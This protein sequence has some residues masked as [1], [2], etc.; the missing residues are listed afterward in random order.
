MT[1]QK[2]DQRDRWLQ[3]MQQYY[4]DTY[5]APMYRDVRAMLPASTERL[6]TLSQIV[7]RNV[8]AQFKCVPDVAA[9]DKALTEMYETH[10]EYT[11]L[12]TDRLQIEEDAGLE[13]YTDEVRDLW[14]K[15]MKRVQERKRAVGAVE[16]KTNGGLHATHRDA[17]Q[18]N[19]V[20]AV[21]E[22]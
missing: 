7:K 19:A 22:D 18:R 20:E 14:A 9:V 17:V 10:P 21:S 1:T 6:T 3:A 16:N 11:A 2:T 13:D 12:A 4:R 8:P 5:P 15:V